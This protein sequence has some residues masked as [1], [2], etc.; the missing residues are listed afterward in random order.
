MTSGTLQTPKGITPSVKPLGSK[1]E[2][3][4]TMELYTITPE[5]AQQWLEKSSP[6]RRLND[7]QVQ[8]YA[9]DMKAGNWALNAETIK[10]D[11]HN[12]LIDGQH[13]L[14]AV[15]ISETPIQT[16]V[17]Q[18]LPPETMDTVD[19]GRNRTF[20]NVL[21]IGGTTNATVMSSAARLWYGYENELLGGG[22]INP[23]HRDLQ[24]VIEAH[25]DLHDRVLDYSGSKNMRKLGQPGAVVFVYSGAYERDPEKAKEWFEALSSG[26]GLAAD[27]PA[28][29]LRERLIALRTETP[30]RR[31]AE[32][33]AAI[34]IKSWNAFRAGKPMNPN[35]LRYRS[36]EKFPRF[37]E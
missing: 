5:L 3:K 32:E 21:Q 26:T 14:W 6:N 13:R 1:V 34:A 10:F 15:L 36:N 20:A 31:R 19:T 18:N 24:A 7:N 11:I 25:P 17:A 29:L 37:A 12:N 4:P 2:A 30:G 33:T 16:F 22:T 8:R 27:N 23:S 35:G 9:R 28:Y